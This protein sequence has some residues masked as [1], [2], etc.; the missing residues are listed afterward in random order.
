MDSDNAFLNGLT[1]YS[2]YSATRHEVKSS[3]LLLLIMVLHEPQAKIH[4][5]I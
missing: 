4:Q 5:G 1:L 3:L 2:L